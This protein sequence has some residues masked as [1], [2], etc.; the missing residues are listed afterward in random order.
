[1]K[2]ALVN[3]SPHKDGC[4]NRALKE[5][6]TEL[7]NNGIEA[8]IF[9]IGSSPVS[10]CLGCGACANLGKCVIDDSVNEFA[11]SLKE[12][13]GFIFG[14]P[15]HYAAISGGLSSF[16]SRLFFSAKKQAPFI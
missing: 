4:T 8:E 7:E 12:Y 5:I 15:V 9:W 1:M 13:D 6:K 11:A 3:G 14:S 2:A 10:S 16:M